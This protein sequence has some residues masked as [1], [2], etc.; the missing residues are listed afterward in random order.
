M[1]WRAP[2]APVEKLL[3]LRIVPIDRGGGKP[4]VCEELYRF[5]GETVYVN[6]GAPNGLT[7]GNIAL[8]RMANGA[9]GTGE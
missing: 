2:D 4:Q 9:A 8:S 5:G 1:S 7:E 3:V 6:R